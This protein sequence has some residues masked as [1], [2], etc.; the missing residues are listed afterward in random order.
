M[1]SALSSGFCFR[2]IESEGGCGMRAE[3][4]FRPFRG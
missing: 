4:N 3:A 1:G 2:R